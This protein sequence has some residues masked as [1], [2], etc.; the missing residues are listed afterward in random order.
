MDQKT[1]LLCGA[2]LG[3]L[4]VILG[5]FG[6]HAFNAFLV[7]HGRQETYELAVRYQFY[8]AFALLATGIIMK[9]SSQRHLKVAAICFLS[10][11]VFFSGS[12]YLLCITGQ[13]LLGA[14]TPVGGA[15][16]IAGWVL[17]AL[18]IYKEKRYPT[19]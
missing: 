13:K 8:H 2:M 11:I 3:C 16:F 1:T 6:A 14:V 19:T 4:A 7:S 9:F 5:A 10:G 17:L 18:G 12:L 15:L